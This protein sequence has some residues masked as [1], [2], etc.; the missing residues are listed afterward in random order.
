M[1]EKLMKI[2]IH[3]HTG[4]WNPSYIQPECALATPEDMRE[5]YI[6]HGVDKGILLPLI[7]PEF[8]WC[9]NTNEEMEYLA[10]KYSDL[11]YWFCNIDPRMGNN[12]PDYNFSEMLMYYKNKGAR[13]VGEFTAHLPVDDPLME[14]FFYHC[15]ECDMPVLVHISDRKYNDY[16][17]IDDLGLPKI[18]KMLKKYPKLKIIGHSGCFWSEISSDVNHENRCFSN[19][20]KVLE[21]R[22][23]EMLRECP[24]LYCDI[25]ANSGANAM[26]RDPEFTYKFIE[27][28]SDRIMF[29]MDIC[30]KGQ[31]LPLSK[32]LDDAYDND[33]ISYENYYKVCRGNA[34]RFLNLNEV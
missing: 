20:G 18:E 10:N 31:K 24:N 16:G 12:S 5:S 4:M 27:E 26:M 32:W 2:D 29:G 33:C 8:R 13:G 3:S 7:S 22:V 9:V 6:E 11:F 25:S 34:I 21:G 30:Y 1:K 28:F 14:N 23:V 19:K 17:I 15:G